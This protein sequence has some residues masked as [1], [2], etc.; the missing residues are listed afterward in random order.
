[1]STTDYGPIRVLTRGAYDLQK[2]R[3]GTGNRIVGNFR[4][5]L[6]QAPG[7]KAED[8]LSAEDQR[9]IVDL[10]HRHK[11]IADALAKK[12][13][14]REFPGDELISS[15]AE[16]ALVG[17]YLNME[18]LEASNFRQLGKVLEDVPIYQEFLEEVRGIG[19]AMA[20]VIISEIDITKARYV[21]SLWKYAGLDVANGKGRSRK[22][23]HLVLREYVTKDGEVKEKRS[24]TY[25]PFLKTKLVGVLGASFLRS[26]SPYAQYYRDYRHRIESDPTR[27][28][29]KKYDADNPTAWTPLRV[30]QASIRYMVK[31]FLA[32][33]YVAWRTLEKLPVAPDY[34][35]AK[36]GHKHAA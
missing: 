36:L 8:E 18:S 31:R 20:G 25:N 26:A 23:E 1:M 19:P 35:E 2:L 10:K 28:K 3:I 32:D 14:S 5:K 29:V 6:G 27:E 24:I 7:L 34:H 15:R 30:H 22:E 11:R 17:E 33:L 9:M 21:S 16:L 4:A 13:R 12:P